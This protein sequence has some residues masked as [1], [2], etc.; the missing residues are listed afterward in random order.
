[1]AGSGDEDAFVGQ[2]WHP[3]YCRSRAGVREFA[4]GDLVASAWRS[5]HPI[6]CVQSLQ[7]K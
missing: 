4:D 2:G 1:M 7:K 5:P 3:G 6:K